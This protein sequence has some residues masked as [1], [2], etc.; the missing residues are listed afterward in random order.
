MGYHRHS[1]VGAML[2]I[3]LAACGERPAPE[4]GVAPTHTPAP[5]LAPTN[6]PAPALALAKARRWTVDSQNETDILEMLAS[7]RPQDK[8]VGAQAAAKLNSPVVLDALLEA[9]ATT[10]NAALRR[11][12]VNSLKQADMDANIHVWVDWLIS[13]TD[14]YFQQLLGQLL[15]QQGSPALVH[16]LIRQAQPLPNDSPAAIRMGQL[17]N[18]MQNPATVSA[19]IA[20]LDARNTKVVAGCA[21]ALAN[22][23]SVAALEGLITRAA[24][25]ALAGM[26]QEAIAR[27]HNPAALPALK[28][29]AAD[30]TKT[31]PALRRSAIQ[32]LR[33]YPP[34]DVAATLD[35]LLL[36]EPD[37]A[38]YEVA[39]RVHTELRL[40]EPEVPAY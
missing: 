36:Y 16:E 1:A 19:L 23:G 34:A 39:K 8:I 10:T 15:L 40:P 9:T 26:L 3:F 6:A 12:L 14:A 25:P 33:N 13:D 31:W 38:L 24:N 2:L 18:A 30:E 20:G 27:I 5:A 37:E 35:A 4:S 7:E 28:A 29:V 17:L 11:A 21:A 22:I 32:A